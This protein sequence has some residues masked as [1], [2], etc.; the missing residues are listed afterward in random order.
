MRWRP[1][2]CVDRHR[3]S[4]V[5]RAAASALSWQPAGDAGT[6]PPWVL[7]DAVLQ[8]QGRLRDAALDLRA[9]AE[10]GQRLVDVNAAGRLGGTLGAAP[11][12]RGRVA[13]LAVQLRDPGITPGPWQLSCEAPKR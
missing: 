11:A 8:L 5:G 1:W 3:P 7:R 4:W 13:S 6:P 12:W 10:Q 9:R 2:R